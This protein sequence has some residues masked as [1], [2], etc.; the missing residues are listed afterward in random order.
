V[1]ENGRDLSWYKNNNF[2]SSK[3]Y[4]T[5]GKYENF[6]GGY[7]HDLDFGYGHWALYDDM[8]GQ[9][10]F[11]WALSRQGAIWEDL[12][13]D[14]DGQYIEPQAGRYLNQN[15]HE[16]FTPY[17]ADSWREIWFPYKQIGPMTEASEHAV[18]SVGR[19]GDEV[20]IGICALQ[21]INDTL[22]IFADGRKIYSKPLRLKPMGVFQ[23]KLQIPQNTSVRVEIPGKLQWASDEQNILKRPIY[24]HEFDE[25]TVEERASSYFCYVPARRAVLSKRTIPQGA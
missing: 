24:F 20:S 5:V 10:F 15:D 16:F 18:L 23:K 2:G 17:T 14:T 22:D 12:L 19:A 6:F 7:W 11:L 9:K 4:F 3:A 13:T 21:K 1:D 8:P 25:S